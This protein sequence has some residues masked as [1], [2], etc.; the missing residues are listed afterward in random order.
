MSADDPSHP[1]SIQPLYLPPPYQDAAGLGRV[2]LRDGSTARVHPAGPEHHGNLDDFFRRLSPESLERRFFSQSLPDRSMIETMCDSSDPG[3][4]MTLLVSRL[5]R[6]RPYIVAVGSYFRQSSTTAEFAVVVDDQ[7]Q[8]KGLGSILLERLAIL[9]VMHG[10]DRFHALTRPSNIPMVEIFRHSGFHPRESREDGYVT[11]DFPVLPTE[12]SVR[13]TE[14]RDRVFTTASLR[15]FFKPRSV[16]VVGVSDEHSPLGRRVM[17][18]LLSGG[19]QGPV[20]AVDE[21]HPDRPHDQCVSR[22]ADLTDPVD[23]AVIAL[24]AEQVFEA[25]QACG[26]AGT[27]AV[28]VLSPGFA[29]RGDAGARTETRLVEVCQGHGM[30]LIGPNCL[31][32]IN[33]DP[34]VRLNASSSLLHPAPGGMAISSQSSSLALAMLDQVQHR[35]LGVSSLVGIGN[36]ADVSGN[37]LLQYWESDE[38]TRVILLYLESFKNPRRFARIARRV[39]RSKPIVCVKGHQQASPHRHVHSS[40]AALAGADTPVEALLRQTGVIRAEGV[41]D[42]FDLAAALSEQPLPRGR[43]VAVLSDAGGPGHLCVDACRSHGLLPVALD[44]RTVSRLTGRIIETAGEDQPLQFPGVLSGADWDSLLTTLLQCPAV[45]ALIVVLANPERTEREHTLAHLTRALAVARAEDGTEGKPVLLCRMGHGL[46]LPALEAD[47]EK[48]PVYPYPETPPRVLGRMA[49]YA[50]WRT[51][52]SGTLSVFE[53]VDTEQGR[54][55]CQQAVAERGEGWLTAGE[56]RA[57]LEAFG[58]PLPPGGLAADPDSAVARAEHIGYPVAVKLASRVL[59]QKTEI[60]AVHLDLRQANEVR[61][62]WQ[63]IHDVLEEM[64]QLEDMEGVL[65]QPMLTGTEVMVGVTEDPLFGP[66]IA[67]GLGGIHVEV[68]GDV[69]FRVT[70]LTDEDARAMIGDVR[71]HQLLQGYRGHPPADLVALEEILLRVSYLVEE[72]P[73]L[74]ELDLNPIFAGQPGKGCWIADA[75][76]RVRPCTGTQPL[77]YAL[78]P[79]RR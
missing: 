65:V 46:Q 62:A 72:I 40:T 14:A 57:V 5:K 33:T 17:D 31:G 12:D 25:V 64:D 30:R 21:Q 45:D 78:P 6:G 9:A 73:E 37:D 68:L 32:L 22:M 69:T 50:A 48:L 34:A 8:G 79:L 59:N 43:R 27:R 49:D 44:N 58:M 74:A 42:L 76:M 19:F 77:R 38:H 67:F 60:G 66:L 20:F 51:R 61:Q 7:L 53:D 4:G 39:S 3:D 13:V 70:P 28:L 52:E 15:P 55:H 18:A 29:D 36:K 2:I 47:G 56:T 75:R 41:E 54:A 24:P 10:F 23:L 11:L 71:G 26:E 16:A 1:D 35:G 63:A